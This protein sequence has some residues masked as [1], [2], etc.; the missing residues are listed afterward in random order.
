MDV[1]QTKS[2]RPS[3]S[4]LLVLARRLSGDAAG[5][6]PCTF[7]DT[8]SSILEAQGPLALAVC[9][10]GQSAF[11]DQST[12]EISG[13]TSGSSAAHKAFVRSI[14]R[15]IPASYSPQIYQERTAASTPSFPFD[16]ANAG[17]DQG[18]ASERSSPGL[19]WLR[20]TQELH[21]ETPPIGPQESHAAQSGGGMTVDEDVGMDTDASH[22]VRLGSLAS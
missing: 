11:F 5:R 12:F 7:P 14:Q 19:D 22:P 15:R 1:N 6:A 17:G 10:Q 3:L 2:G 21:L 4:L 20:K 16:A 18:P 13:P 9:E 8:Y